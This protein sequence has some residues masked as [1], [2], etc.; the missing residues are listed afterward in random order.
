MAGAKTVKSSE[1]KPALKIEIAKKNDEYTMLVVRDAVVSEKASDLSGNGIYMFNVHKDANK[2]QVTRDIEKAYG[3]SPRKVTM[4][5]R[6]G[7][8][9]GSGKRMGRRSDI[10]RAIVIMPAS[11]RLPL[12]EQK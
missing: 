9:L 7:K 10:K 6:K 4:L 8:V 2:I 3:M 12:F 1:K 11:K 5:R